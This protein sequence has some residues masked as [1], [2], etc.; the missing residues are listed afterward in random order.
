M[1]ELSKTLDIPVKRLEKV[2]SLEEQQEQIVSLDSPT[3]VSDEGNEIT[4]LDTICDEIAETCEERADKT[5]ICEFLNKAIQNLLNEREAFIVRYHYGLN[6]EGEIKTLTELSTILK[7]SLERVR[8]VELKALG[9]LKACLS[10]QFGSNW[11]L[12]GV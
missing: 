12:I 11:N 10:L 4:L 2:L 5:I 6:P 1:E 3:S 9:K 8:Q 7:V